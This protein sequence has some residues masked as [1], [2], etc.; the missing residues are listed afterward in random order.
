MANLAHDVCDVHGAS[1]SYIKTCWQS[2][3]KVFPIGAWGSPPFNKKFA[4]STFPT[5]F[6]FPPTKIQFKTI[7]KIK[8]FLAVVIVCVPFLFVLISYSFKRQII[9]MLID[10]QYSQN[11]VFSFEKLSNRQNHSS[12]GS[13]HLVKIHQQCSQLF[14]KDS[15]KILKF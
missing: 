13:H 12:S 11:A 15:W 14:E 7:K 8:I 3:C 9:L 4:R 5:K 2:L 6:L 1:S 10:F